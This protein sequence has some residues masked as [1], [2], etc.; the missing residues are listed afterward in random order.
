[1]KRPDA[2]SPTGRS[3]TRSRRAAAPSVIWSRT[4]Q[5]LTEPTRAQRAGRRADRSARARMARQKLIMESRIVESALA[6]LVNWLWQGSAMRSPRRR[7]F[8]RRAGSGHHALCA[9]D[10]LFIVLAL[11]SSF[12]LPASRLPATA[13]NLV[14]AWSPGSAWRVP[15]RKW[16]LR[17]R[18]ASCDR[19]AVVWS[20]LGWRS[21]SHGG[22]A[23]IARRAAPRAVPEACESRLHT[24]LLQVPGRRG[25]PGVSDDVPL[26]RCS[27]CRPVDRDRPADAS[28][29][30]T[31]SISIRS[32]CTSGRTC[33]DATIWRA[34]FSGYRRFRRPSSRAVWW[35]DRQLHLEREAACDDWAVQAH[36]I[37][38]GLAVCLTKLAALPGPTVTRCWSRRRSSFAADRAN[39]A[40]A[41]STPQHVDRRL[42]SAVLVAPRP[43]LCRCTVA[44]AWSSW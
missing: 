22:L 39:R 3:W 43:A 28:T 42:R 14:D 11:S 17:R 27:V 32:S 4:L 37:R 31:T 34:S 41:R 19:R 23:L 35:I 29:D 26:R 12:Q 24:W 2:R 7:Y 5:R 15:D 18:A 6:T 13:R 38:Q 8:V 25:E 21:L 33:N 30:S 20:I 10:R 36:R 40:A 16:K 9:G 1:M 44:S